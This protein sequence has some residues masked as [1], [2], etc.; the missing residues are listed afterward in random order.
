MLGQLH[1]RP[2]LSTVQTHDLLSD[3]LSFARAD[4]LP[5]CLPSAAVSLQRI[6]TVHSHRRLT[7]L[8]RPIAFEKVRQRI[9]AKE[10]LDLTMAERIEQ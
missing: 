6:Q 2:R 5:T 10:A 3:S 4:T 7:A 8:R 1:T 9:P